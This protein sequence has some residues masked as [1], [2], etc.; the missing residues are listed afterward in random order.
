MEFDIYTFTAA[1]LCVAHL[2][3]ALV[4]II[5]CVLLF[6]VTRSFGWLFLAVIFIEPLYLAIW[7][8]GRGLSPLWYRSDTFGPGGS[9]VEA[10][11]FDF[12]TLFIFAVVG[13]LIL[14]RRAK[15]EAPSP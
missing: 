4:A 12:P 5:L 6:R 9:P 14:Y 15:Q 1:A 2:A 13:L 7:R 10:I 8:A 11:K 3:L